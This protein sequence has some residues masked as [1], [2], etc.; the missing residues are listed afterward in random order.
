MDVPIPPSS[1]GTISGSHDRAVPFEA[2]NDFN[3]ELDKL[4]T[5]EIASFTFRA[6][7]VLQTM[8]PEGYRLALQDFRQQ[9]LENFKEV[10]SNQFPAP[11]AYHFYRTEW[12]YENDIQRL[13]C[14]RDVWESLVYVLY[15]LVI[16][17]FRCAH[18]PLQTSRGTMEHLLSN[19]MN[20]KLG[21]ITDLLNFASNQGYDLAC[22]ALID[23]E[24]IEKIRELNRVRNGFSH[25]A[26]I[27]EEQARQLF[28][29]YYDQVLSILQ[30]VEALG[31]VTLIRFAGYGRQPREYRFETFVG[32]A[33]TRTYL[34]QNLSQDQYNACVDY[35]HPDNIL[36]LFKD[37]IYSVSPFLHF[38][39]RDEGH[40]TR[41]CFYKTRRGGHFH[42]EVLGE[43][44]EQ[45]FQQAVFANEV[46]E[47]Q[48]LLSPDPARRRRP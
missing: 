14:L 29:V 31:N 45:P 6:S 38:V 46:N 24:I 35:L 16:G 12:G 3:E 30:Q 36:A 1:D 10:I 5:V 7:Q 11:V 18:I 22:S 33:M 9:R 47:L 27:S 8:D 37:R 28:D 13:H 39:S 23:V 17:E 4:Y 20:D 25:S 19:T 41:L 15:A 40:Q 43:V 26:A 32:H 44:R 21:T 34:K 2:N 48:A 42:Y